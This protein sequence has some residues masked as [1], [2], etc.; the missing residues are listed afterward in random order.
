LSPTTQNFVAEFTRPASLFPQ[1]KPVKVQPGSIDI[2]NQ[3]QAI[4][5]KRG[6]A[7]SSLFP[8]LKPVEAQPDSGNITNQP[9]VVTPKR[10][11]AANLFPQLRPV[12]AQPGSPKS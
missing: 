12:G 6:H 8:Q 3:L 10:G 9:Q 1:L 2:T 7:A 11:L 4:T 5:P